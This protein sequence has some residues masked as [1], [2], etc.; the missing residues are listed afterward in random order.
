MAKHSTPKSGPSKVRLIVFE[1]EV[2]DGDLSQIANVLQNAF[3]SGSPT[4]K[5][6]YANP[7]NPAIASELIEEAADS[8][9]DLVQ[10]EPTSPSKPR[11]PR[12]PRVGKTPSV[13]D[14]ID[15]ST[16]PSLKDFVANYEVK[17]TFDKYLVIALWYRDARQ[18]NTI[19]VDHVYTAFKM[20]GWSTAANDFSKPLRN[21]RDEQSFKGG[22]RE[23]WSLT[24]PGAGKIESKKKG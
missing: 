22:S 23:G 4:P 17:T 5:I 19:S 15:F 6:I 9:D 21:L 16:D 2:A 20:L 13:L 18:L 3:K 11:G 12:K 7:N 14:G 1:A 8:D 24:L 10:D